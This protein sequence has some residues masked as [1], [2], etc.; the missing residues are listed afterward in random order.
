MVLREKMFQ[1][2]LKGVRNP[3][4]VAGYLLGKVRSL[5]DKLRSH[6]DESVSLWGDS[7]AELGRANQILLAWSRSLERTVQWP[8]WSRRYFQGYP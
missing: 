1:Q 3:R 2:V 7:A 8:D 6:V 4:S 5:T